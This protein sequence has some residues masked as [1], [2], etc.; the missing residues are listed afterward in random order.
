MLDHSQRLRRPTPKR[1]AMPAPDPNARDPIAGQPR[2]Q[3][4]RSLVRSPLIDVG[5][6]SYYDDPAGTERV[7]TENVLYHY[8]PEKLII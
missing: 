2:V 7:E 6:Y 4:L 3:Y 1:R 5:D 8:G